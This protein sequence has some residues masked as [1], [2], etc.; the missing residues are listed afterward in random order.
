MEEKSKPSNRLLS[1]KRKIRCFVA[2]AFGKP[3][4]DWIYDQYISKA[5]QDAGMIPVRVDK[6]IHNERIDFKIRESIEKADVVVADLT[7]ARPSVYW[8]AG[9]AERRVPVVYTCRSDHFQSQTD[10]KNGNLQV[11]FD[12]RNANIITWTGTGNKHFKENLRK[13]LIHVTLSLREEMEKGSNFRLEREKFSIISSEQ[14]CNL[15]SSKTPSLLKKLGYRLLGEIY[16]GDFIS[17]RFSFDPK[18]GG[19]SFGVYWKKIDNVALLVMCLYCGKEL[20]KSQLKELKVYVIEKFATGYFAQWKD[21]PA[22][23]AIRSSSGNEIQAIRRLVLIP[24]LGKVPI[25]RTDSVFPDW[26]RSG[27]YLHYYYPKLSLFD[28][29]SV[30]SSSEFLIIGDIKSSS[31]FGDY[32]SKA[33][34]SIESER[35]SIIFSKKA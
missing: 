12:L 21:F 23:I 18:L 32:L 22:E 14:R 4:T 19:R 2:M 26:H 35:T 33:I 34:N 28:S 16:S 8:E 5:I 15:V 1:D 10:D 6:I 20:N 7:Y 30:S 11:H 29:Q 24:A 31:D 3:D 27:N 25:T 13:R 17:H 9:Y